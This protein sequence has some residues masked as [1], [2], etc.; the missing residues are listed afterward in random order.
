MP[1]NKLT[2]EEAYAKLEQIAAELSGNEVT[3]DE[4]IALYEEGVR[5]SKFCAEAL[6]NAKQKIEVLENE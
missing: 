3:L 5:L 4:T 2:F 1:E 6:E